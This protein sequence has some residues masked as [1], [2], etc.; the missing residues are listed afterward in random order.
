MTDNSLKPLDNVFNYLPRTLRRELNDDDQIRSWALQALRRV[1][2]SDRYI[3][4]IT[5]HDITNHRISLPDDVKKV[6]KVSYA[7]SQ[8]SQLEI[9]SLCRCEA[10]TDSSTYTLEDDCVPIYHQLFL[11]S[12]YYHNTFKPMAYKKS[13]LTDNYVCNV[14][15]GG[16]YGFYSLDT[17]GTVMTFSEKEGFVAIEYLAE[18]KDT[19]GNFLVPDIE[20]LWQGLASWIKAK[21]FEERTIV[22][23]Q[24]SDQRYL[25][26]LQESKVWLTQAR[27]ILKLRNID[28]ALHRNLVQGSSRILRAHLLSRTHD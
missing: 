22:S 14:N 3:K 19:D 24:N 18:I 27:G 23:E 20:E 6:Y 2:H 12:D 1:H 11:N 10:Q 8:P 5:F 15:W 7:T 9:D 4:D 13:R 25:A 16:C 21:F 28:T 17:T 26:N